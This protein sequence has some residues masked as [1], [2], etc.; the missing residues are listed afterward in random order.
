[1]GLCGAVVAQPDTATATAMRPL[2][3]S[4]KVEVVPNRSELRLNVSLRD[5]DLVGALGEIAGRGNLQIIV[6]SGVQAT[7]ADFAIENKSPEEALALVCEA[8]RLSAQWR[9]NAWIISPNAAPFVRAETGDKLDLHF[10]AVEA[11]ALLEII[12]T[13]FH[14]AVKVERDVIGTIPLVTLKGRTPREAIEAV[15]LAV[16][17][18]VTQDPKGTFIVSAKTP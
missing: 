7:V 5:A 16:D 6:K 18:T 11:K 3:P 15:A 2:H 4:I 10:R 12:S 8:A 17:A 13:Q 9:N 1:M 14:V